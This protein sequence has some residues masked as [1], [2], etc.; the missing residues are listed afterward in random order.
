M[1]NGVTVEYTALVIDEQRNSDY[2]DFYSNLVQYLSPLEPSS[3]SHWKLSPSYVLPA[4]EDILQEQNEG[5]TND[6][7]PLLFGLPIEIL[8]ETNPVCKLVLETGQEINIPWP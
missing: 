3:L 1:E 5:Q 7:P 4:F 2:W 8:M 6:D